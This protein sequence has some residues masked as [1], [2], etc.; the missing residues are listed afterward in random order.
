MTLFGSLDSFLPVN[1]S[2][3]VFVCRRLWCLNGQSS[4]YR[5]TICLSAYRTAELNALLSRRC[6]NSSGRIVCT[7]TY[8]G[9]LSHIHTSVRHIFQRLSVSGGL[10]DA[11]TARFTY[12]TTEL[13]PRIK[14][15]HDAHVLIVVPSYFDFV[16]VRNYC[17]DRHVNYVCASMC[18][19]L[20]CVVLHP[21]HQL[22]RCDVM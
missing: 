1:T 14:V 3:C 7:T 22:I 13:L 15:A 20:R 10:V 9:V 11:A 12:F 18:V 19:V 16:R 2:V 4:K 6:N 8:Q 5:Q 17:R 21:C